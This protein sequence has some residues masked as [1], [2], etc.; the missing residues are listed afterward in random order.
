MN[1]RGGQEKE[2][3]GVFGANDDEPA[4][5]LR[6]CLH[7]E[8][9]SACATATKH[10]NT[11]GIKLIVLRSSRGKRRNDEEMSSRDGV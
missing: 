7:D 1:N 6:G 10:I 5:V 11:N 4:V 2:V 9:V 3:V 8:Y